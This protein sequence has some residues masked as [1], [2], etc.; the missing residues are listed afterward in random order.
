MSQSATATGTPLPTFADQTAPSD[1]MRGSALAG[2]SIIVLFF[3]VLGVWSTTAPLNGAVV[4]NG[5][6][7]VEGNRKSVQHLDGGIVKELRVKE[8]DKVNVGDVLI[9]LDDTQARAEL[10]V[11]TEQFIVLRA[12]EER[13]RAELDRRVSL[14]MPDDLRA[15]NDGFHVKSVWDGQV[16]QM[17]SRLDALEGQRSVIKEKISQ[18]EQQI[19][20]SQAQVT[21]FNAQLTSVRNEM[22][23]IA[24]LMERGLIAKPRYLQLERSASGLEGQAADTIAGIARAR[25]AIAEQKQQMAQLDNDRMADITKDLR[26][27]QA[28]LLEVIPRLMN[29]R[30]VL[31]RMEIRSPY[32]GRVVGLN[33][34][35]VGAVIL[36]GDKIL[37][38]VPEK[39]SLIVESQVSVDDISELRPDMRAEIHLTAY[40]Q[41]ITPT[42][43]G[44]V[45]QISADRLTDTRTGTPYYTALLR[46]DENELAEMP[47][48]RLY[49]GMPAMVTV[50]TVART[51]FD[52]LVG[53]LA[54]SFRQAF[55]QK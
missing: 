3:G 26:D 22:E 46:I 54:Q 41:R 11:L 43:H 12:S 27:T 28:K 32:A 20:G 40:K 29:A 23:S 50:P 37:D 4:A 48:I 10:N 33:V 42:I 9:V 7:K 25:Q 47:D 52:Y 31:S 44:E 6:V 16:R 36:R 53:P 8:G 45:I 18:L 49:P 24:P 13:L 14:V 21:A 30:A 17:Q 19:V 39:E 35:S 2:W 1:G 38:V 55:R 15:I 51:A 34:F 5:V